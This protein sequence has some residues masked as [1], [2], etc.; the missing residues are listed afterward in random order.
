[1]K[2]IY[3]TKLCILYELRLDTVCSVVVVRVAGV[4]WHLVPVWSVDTAPASPCMTLD[5]LTCTHTNNSD[6][7]MLTCSLT[8]MMTTIFDIGDDI[9]PADM[10]S[11]TNNSYTQSVHEHW[12][13]KHAGHHYNST[14]P[15]PIRVKSC[16]SKQLVL[17]NSS[18]WFTHCV[19][20][21]RLQDE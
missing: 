6:S 17:Y 10:L 19:N 9:N 2:P 12:H 5:P 20:I 18:Y 15:K 7:D 13:C 8:V 14:T 11:Q 4:S 21:T 16:N 3:R 1:M